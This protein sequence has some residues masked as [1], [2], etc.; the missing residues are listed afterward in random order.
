MQLSSNASEQAF[1]CP[2]LKEN[3]SLLV[4]QQVACFK[5]R[6]HRFELRLVNTS[7]LTLPCLNFLLRE[8]CKRVCYFRMWPHIKGDLGEV[9]GNRGHASKSFFE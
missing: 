4:L 2:K 9:R 6:N 1:T 3:T 7:L 8:L 5:L